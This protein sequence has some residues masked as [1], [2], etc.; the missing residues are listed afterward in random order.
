MSKS[1][2]H[3]TYSTFEGFFKVS[4]TLPIIDH[5]VEFN[6]SSVNR[7]RTQEDNNCSSTSL[8]ICRGVLN[9]DLTYTKAVKQLDAVALKDLDIL[10]KSKC[11]A[12]AIEFI[13]TLLEPECRPRHIGILQPCRRLCKGKLSIVKYLCTSVFYRENDYLFQ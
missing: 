7:I 11:S 9:Y 13:C 4:P 10:I 2:A 5:N 12:R 8:D 1:K 6:G 3:T